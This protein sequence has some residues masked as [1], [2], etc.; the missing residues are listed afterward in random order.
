MNWL[1][2]EN[3]AD[4]QNESGTVDV[5]HKHN[6]EHIYII[7]VNATKNFPFKSKFN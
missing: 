6:E 7:F 4:A 3:S 1:K 5:E 2:F